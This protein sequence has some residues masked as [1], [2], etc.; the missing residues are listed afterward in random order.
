MDELMAV[1][2]L[3]AAIVLGVAG[4]ILFKTAANQLVEGNV[5]VVSYLANPTLIVGLSVYFLSALLYIHALKSL[6][7]FA[8][9]ASLSISYIFIAIVGW[10]LFSEPVSVRQIM[11]MVLICSGVLLLWR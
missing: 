9:Y 1:T 10:L 2:F 4:Q 6:P 8:S 11:A 5:P 7:L 3:A